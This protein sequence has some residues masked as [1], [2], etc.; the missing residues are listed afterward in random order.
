[1]SDTKKIL[2]TIR[3]VCLSLFGFWIFLIL[4]W[5]IPAELNHFLIFAVVAL[6][7]LIIASISNIYAIWSDE[8]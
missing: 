5:N 6:L 3:D 4:G 7:V 1:M 2:L 8:D